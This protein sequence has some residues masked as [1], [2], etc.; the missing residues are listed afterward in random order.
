VA[1]V[2]PALIVAMGATA[3][4][5]VLGRAL[6]ILSNRGTLLQ[7]PN[8]LAPSTRV[9]VT[10]HPS[11]LLRVL[12]ETRDAEYSKFVEDLKIAAKYIRN[13]RS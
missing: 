9:L 4:R 8:E 10:V 13:L 5:A 2:Q 12:P 6:P 11:Y 1:T 7:P 3:V